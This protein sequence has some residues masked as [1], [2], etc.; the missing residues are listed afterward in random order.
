MLVRLFSFVR[1]CVSTGFMAM[2]LVVGLGEQI[3]ICMQYSEWTVKPARIKR[4]NSV[5]FGA[6]FN[7]STLISGRRF[8][9]GVASLMKGV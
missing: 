2:K 9:Y 3:Q 5:G 7:G 1:G 4:D 6:A 8:L